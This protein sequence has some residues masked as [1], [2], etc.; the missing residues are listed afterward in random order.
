[1]RIGAFTALAHVLRA[2][3]DATGAAQA[4]EDALSEC[5]AIGDVVRGA[6]MREQ[7]AVV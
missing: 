1:M 4:L 6:R 5:E 7:L 2:R 3:Q